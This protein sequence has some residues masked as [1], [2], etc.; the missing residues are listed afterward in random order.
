MVQSA[1]F[2][3]FQGCAHIH[4]CGIHRLGRRYAKAEIPWASPQYWAASVAFSWSCKR[5][6]IRAMNSLLVGFPLVLLTV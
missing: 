3:G 4:F 2:I 5:S 1:K 6:A